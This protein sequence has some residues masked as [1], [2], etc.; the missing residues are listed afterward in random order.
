MRTVSLRLSERL[1]ERLAAAAAERGA[2][3]SALIRKV[4][5]AYLDNGKRAQ[6]QSCLSLMEDLVGSVE[7]PADLSTNARHLHDFGR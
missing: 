6:R 1:S 2:T 7:G 3:K 5:E 4:L